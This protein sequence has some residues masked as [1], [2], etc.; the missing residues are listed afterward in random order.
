MPSYPSPTFLRKVRTVEQALSTLPITS[1]VTPSPQNPSLSNSASSLVII[2]I[3][4]VGT[5]YPL[6]VRNT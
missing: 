4:N 6:E 2:V 5:Q 1:I 3:R